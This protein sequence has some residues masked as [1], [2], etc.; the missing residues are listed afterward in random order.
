MQIAVGKD[1]FWDSEILLR[2]QRDVIIL[3]S[4]IITFIRK[5]N[6]VLNLW[7]TDARYMPHDQVWIAHQLSSPV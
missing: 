1:D 3:L 6:K 2:W 5:V 7:K 4:I